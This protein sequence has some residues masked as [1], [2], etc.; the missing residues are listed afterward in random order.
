MVTDE[1][2]PQIQAIADRIADGWGETIEVGPGWFDL[3]IRLDAQLA[4][5][6]PGYVIEQCKAKYGGLRYYA[7]PEDPEDIDTQLTFN[8]IIW[9]AE[10]ESTHICEEC[11]NPGYQVT[12]RGW[13]ST[14]CPE[15]TQ[16]QR[17]VTSET[18]ARTSTEL[19]TKSRPSDDFDEIGLDGLPPGRDC[20]SCGLALEP[21][22]IDS[23]IA[24]IWLCPT[25]GPIDHTANPLSGS[26]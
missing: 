17:A 6:S 7:R 21:G 19:A 20:P 23:T 2:P 14:L 15:H 22:H 5:L 1:L 10:G 12:F 9:A 3:L 13:I 11:G 26:Q 4:R 18:I 24:L 8:E 25:H 16:R